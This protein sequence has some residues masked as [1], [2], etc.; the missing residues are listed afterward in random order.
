[1]YILGSYVLLSS[2]SPRGPILASFHDMYYCTTSRA[3]CSLLT[4]LH[5]PFTQQDDPWAPQISERFEVRLRKEESLYVKWCETCNFYRPP[6]ASHCSICDNCVDRFDH[7]CPWTGTCIGRRNYRTFLWFVNLVLWNCLSIVAFSV[8][9]LALWNRTEGPLGLSNL[10]GSLT[11]RL[12]SRAQDVLSLILCAFCT[13][14]FLAVSYLSVLHWYFTTVNIST[15]EHFAQSYAGISNPFH[16]GWFG[17]MIS[18]FC[19]PPSPPYSDLRKEAIEDA[20]VELTVAT[21]DTTTALAST[22]V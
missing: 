20:Q 6:R 4:S 17:N 18:L 1:M 12:G 19:I 8:L 11:E 21:T 22:G 14:V 3:V 5:F 16:R 2:S 10:G 15:K 7:H 13:L 9:K